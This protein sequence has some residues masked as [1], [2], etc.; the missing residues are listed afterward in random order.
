MNLLYCGDSGIEIGVMMSVLSVAEKTS[1]PLDVYILTAGFSVGDK[2]F[3]PISEDFSEKLKLALR[4][5]GRSDRVWL[6]DLTKEILSEPP[7]AN[8][9]TRFTPM[10][11][12]RLYADGVADLP[13]KIMYLDSDVMCVSDPK[14]LYETDITEYDIAGVPDR[15][16]SLVFDGGIFRRRYINSGVLLLNLRQI[17]ESGCF[18]K[19]RLMCA[20][21]KMF[22]PDQTALNKLAKKKIL[23]RRFN[24]QKS[25]RMDTVFRHFTT[26]LHILPYPHSQTVKPWQPERMHKVLKNYKYDSL[27]YECEERMKGILKK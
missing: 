5:R 7:L 8:M 25:E 1:E 9:S 20:E 17:K 12:L 15:Y 19:A 26:T 4:D 2:R 21:K 22:M 10:C 27:C 3:I 23:P 16:G 24:C 13:E 11:M 6:F 14:S 18:E